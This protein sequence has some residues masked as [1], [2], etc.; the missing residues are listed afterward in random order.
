MASSSIS[1]TAP[2]S[3]RQIGEGPVMGDIPAKDTPS[4]SSPAA[5]SS[6]VFHGF[7]PGDAGTPS[8]SSSSASALLQNSS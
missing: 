3:P 8:C 7:R 5:S 6:S 4:S 2:R 1:S